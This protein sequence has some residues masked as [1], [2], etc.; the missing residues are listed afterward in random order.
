M[1]GLVAQLAPTSTD[2]TARCGACHLPDL[3]DDAIIEL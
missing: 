3:P 1:M 2:G